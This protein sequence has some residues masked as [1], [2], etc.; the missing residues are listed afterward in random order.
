MDDV[1]ILSDAMV[2]NKVGYHLR[3]LR[4]KQSI[5]QQNLAGAANVSL[6]TMKKMEKGEIRSFDAFMRVLRTLGQLEVLQPLVE[7]LK[8][9]PSE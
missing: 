5:T 3:T 1:Y 4:H 8:L 2:L 6:S 9:S 7:E